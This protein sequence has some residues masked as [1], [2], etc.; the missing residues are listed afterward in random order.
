MTPGTRE[1]M[2]RFTTRLIFAVATALV[3][4]MLLMGFVDQ[5]VADC[6]RG[7]DRDHPFVIDLFRAYTELGR[8]DPVLVGTASGILL[9][10]ILLRLHPAATPGFQT[11][12]ARSGK[13][14]LFVFAAVSL[15]GIVTDAVKP[16]LGRARPV[17]LLR[18][19]A[20]GFHPFSFHTGLYSMPSG[21]A[22]TAF[23]LAFALT[24]LYPR[25]RTVWLTL[26]SLLAVSRVMINAH[27]VSDIVA[28]GVIGYLTVLGLSSS[29]TRRGTFQIAD[30]IFPTSAHPLGQL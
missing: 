30:R 4:V 17:E 28:G 21:H 29:I 16:L 23:A 7:I 3:V 9:C 5:P 12:I 25:R 14:S 10:A 8:S 11:R 15:S 19:G 24:T 27:F 13:R 20:H 18:S 26:A 1:F 22:T 2:G 6:L